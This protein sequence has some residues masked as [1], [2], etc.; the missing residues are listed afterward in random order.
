MRTRVDMIGGLVIHDA[1]TLWQCIQLSVA[2]TEEGA[3]LCGFD[4]DASRRRLPLD[5]WLVAISDKNG[6]DISN[7]FLILGFF[8]FA[9]KFS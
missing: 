9:S 6:A 2:T 1:R 8:H 3:R 5:T 4:A 7:L